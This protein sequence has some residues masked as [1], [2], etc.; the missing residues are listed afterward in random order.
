MVTSLFLRHHGERTMAACIRRRHTGPSPGMM[1]WDAIGYTSRS[2][3][4]HING[5]LN[6]ER[7][8]SCVLCPLFEPCETLRFSR[9]LHNGMLPV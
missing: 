6:S 1:V 9:I 2:P 4:V 5:T 8:I 7:Y 3:L